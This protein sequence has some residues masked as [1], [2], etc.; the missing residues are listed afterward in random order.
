MVYAVSR[1]YLTSRQAADL[2]QV[3][4]RTIQLWVEKG[5]LEAWKTAGGHRRI[6]VQ[7]VQAL[8]RDKQRERPQAI[9]RRVLLVEDMASQRLLYRRYLERMLQPVELH[10]A[11]DGFRALMKIGEIR[12]DIVITDLLMPGMDGFRMLEAIRA[13]PQLNGMA[14][15]VLTALEEEAVRQGG[16][17]A[18]EIA[19]LRKPVSYAELKKAVE[20]AL[21]RRQTT[22]LPA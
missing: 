12:P 14:L 21:P 17:A 5:Q 6:P 11:E 16:M 10:L 2:L 20:E 15:I 9:P 19:L 22:E 3:S 4:Q 8:I 13:T 18:G 7:A 1:E